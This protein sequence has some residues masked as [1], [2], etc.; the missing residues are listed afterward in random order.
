MTSNNTW[1]ITANGG[2]AKIVCNLG[3]ESSERIDS[4]VTDHSKAQDLVTDRS[5]RTFSSV[6]KS[7]SAMEEHSD[8]V[9]N[10]EKLFAEH[11]SRHLLKHFTDKQF[12]SLVLVCSPRTLGDLRSAFPQRLLDAIVLS[13]DKDFTQLSDHELP[14]RILSLVKENR[15]RKLVY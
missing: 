6:G 14:Q 10:N 9:R 7:R 12:G 3:A 11:L 1:A 5:G 2:R 8:P 15:K 4:F 13:I